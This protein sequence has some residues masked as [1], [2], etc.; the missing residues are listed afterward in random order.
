MEWNGRERNFVYTCKGS[1]FHQTLHRMDEWWCV[2]LLDPQT[3]RAIPIRTRFL[4]PQYADAQEPTAAVHCLTEL[5]AA[6]LFNVWSLRPPVCRAASSSAGK[7]V[8]LANHFG[9]KVYVNF[10]K[11]LQIPQH[12]QFKCVPPKRKKDP[13][14][15]LAPHAHMV[16][17][18]PQQVEYIPT[19]ELPNGQPPVYFSVA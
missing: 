10:N 1:S 9:L 18:P 5:R 12:R 19:D 15:I 2:L 7:L 13:P 3:R 4:M 11:L 6:K 14:Q 8:A 16:F 17:P